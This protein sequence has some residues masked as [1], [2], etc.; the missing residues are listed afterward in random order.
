[1]SAWEAQYKAPNA[2]VLVPPVAEA[3]SSWFLA[4]VL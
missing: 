1:M 2:A 4:I 3:G